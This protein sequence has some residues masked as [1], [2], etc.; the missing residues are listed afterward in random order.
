MERSRS[1]KRK[2]TAPLRPLRVFFAIFAVKSFY[3]K[4]RPGLA[5]A[6]KNDDST[7]PEIP[8]PPETANC[9]SRVPAS[10]APQ[11]LSLRSCATWLIH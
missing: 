9:T 1:R 5:K 7:T 4:V 2:G 8:T 3:R 10:A 11:L 6:A